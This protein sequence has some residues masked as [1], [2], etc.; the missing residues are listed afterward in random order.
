MSHFSP[1]QLFDKQRGCQHFKLA[2]DVGLLGPADLGP[3]GGAL[4]GRRPTYA[5][6]PEGT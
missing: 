1:V 5:A 4:F 2:S 3:G 6:R